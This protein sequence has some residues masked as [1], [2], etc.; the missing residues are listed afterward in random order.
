MVI[1]AGPYGVID[2]AATPSTA[3]AGGAP[4]L[5]VVW[6]DKR[7]FR[8]EDDDDG[9][10]QTSFVPAP[11]TDHIS[12]AAGSSRGAGPSWRTPAPAS[13]PAS[14][15]AAGT[16]RADAPGR[17]PG[18]HPVE[19]AIAGPAR[20]EPGPASS[21]PLESVPAPVLA[22][23]SRAELDDS[24]HQRHA[25]RSRHIA[26][27][28]KTRG[29]RRGPAE[30]SHPRRARLRRRRI[31]RRVVLGTVIVVIA[32]VVTVLIQSAI[33]APFTVPSVSMQNTLETGDR[34]L[35]DKIGYG[36]SS[37]HRGDVVVFSDPGGWLAGSKES[38]RA[39][40][41]GYLVKRVIGVPGDHVTCCSTDGRLSVNGM[42]LYEDYAVL[43]A[44]EHAA[45]S[46]FDVTVPAGALWVLGDNRYNSHDSSKTQGLPSKGFVPIADVVGQ[47][48]ARVWPVNRLGPIGSARETFASVPDQTCPI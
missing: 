32:F 5:G 35:V 17:E 1:D 39:G 10:I 41:D 36:A 14:A 22:S 16:A 4:Q 3:D 29:R 28:P 12:L 15:P 25:R 20:A 42:E 37:I 18:L 46:P 44:G 43:P 21:A 38:A 26:L 33:I 13:A 27:A 2:L 9:T 40:D 45:A 47:A 23:S 7:S 30:T 34:I 48:V 19:A 6:W 11:T 31:R 8:E 24:E